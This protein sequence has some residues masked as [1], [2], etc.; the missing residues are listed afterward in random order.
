MSTR[1]TP[2]TTALGAKTR[3]EPATAESSIV[4]EKDWVRPKR[5]LMLPFKVS[6][7]TTGARAYPHGRPNG[8]TAEQAQ[9]EQRH[10]NE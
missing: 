5:S 8:A 3:R 4:H 6:A 7:A 1:S 10:G 9:R 2:T